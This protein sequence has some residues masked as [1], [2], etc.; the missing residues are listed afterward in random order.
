MKKVLLTGATGFLGHFLTK[1]LKTNHEVVTMGMQGSDILADI[2][3]KVPDVSQ[4][5]DLVVH[6]AGKA[7]VVP[8]SDAE[9]QAFFEV[10]FEG[11]RRFCESFER[12]ANFPKFFVFISTVAV[13]G[14]ETGKKISED[15]PLNGQSP[16]AKSKI[17]AEGFLRQWCEK[18][19]IK[20]LIL[21]LPLVAGE[22]PPG[23]LAA[24]IN[25]IKKGFYFGIGGSKARKSVVLA[26]DV[27]HLISTWDGSTQGTFNLRGS[28]DPTFKQLE[29]LICDQLGKKGVLKLPYWIAKSLALIGDITPKFPLNPDKLQKIV[30]DLTFDDSKA[31]KELNWS[32]R[33]VTEHFKIS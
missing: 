4:Q 21:R 23:N 22:N 24:M 31:I 5:Y 12:T 28:Q 7:H 9:A 14:L 1:E 27:A 17:Q 19:G 26:E 10:N 11:T 32:P 6:N 20:L 13:Y 16:Y 3:Q 15:H 18:Y 33:N 25:G 29:E 2:T 30:S 8:K